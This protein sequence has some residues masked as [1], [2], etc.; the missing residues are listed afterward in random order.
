VLEKPDML[1]PIAGCVYEGGYHLMKK[2]I[3]F[4]GIVLLSQTAYA[5]DVKGTVEVLKKD[6]KKP[7]KSFANTLVFIEGI[8]TEAPGEPAVMDQKKKRFIPR[9]L[10]I[11]KGQEVIFTNSDRLRHNTFSPH[12]TEPFD[13]GTYGKGKSASVTLQVPGHHRVYC[14]IHQKMIGDIYVVPNHYFAVTDNSGKFTIKDVPEGEYTLKAWHIYGGADERPVRVAVQPIEENFV[15][16]SQKKT[17][18]LEKH[19]NKE[20]KAYKRF[21]SQKGGNGGGY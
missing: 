7:L 18:E 8:E 14:N 2:L 19:S 5:G 9:L 16:T 15:L 6:G 4:I 11:V 3:I 21:G 17:R 1:W 13:L 20:G 12:K 10:P